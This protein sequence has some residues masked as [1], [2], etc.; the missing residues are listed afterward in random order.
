MICVRC[1]QGI[2]GGVVLVIIKNNDLLTLGDGLLFVDGKIE[3]KNNYVLIQK[4]LEDYISLCRNNNVNVIFCQYD[5]YDKEKYVVTEE[6]LRSE[7]ENESE[8]KFCKKWADEYNAKIIEFDFERPGRLSLAASFGSMNIVWQEVDLWLDEFEEAENATITFIE[9][10]EDALSE[11]YTYDEEESSLID[12]FKSVLLSDENFRYS[13]NKA[14]RRLY[15]ESFFKD[16]N[17]KKFLKLVKQEREQY[18]KSFILNE[19]VDRIYN[20]YRNLCY[21]FNVRVS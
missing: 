12:E 10:N 2:K 9:E 6:L 19:M 20:E 11:F 5:Y 17:H 4:P 16:K 13:T 8:Y 18:R 1:S 7:T 3:I 15:M 14:S 21:R